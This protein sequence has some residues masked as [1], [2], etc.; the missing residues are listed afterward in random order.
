ME[1]FAAA[2]GLPT[3]AP[4]IICSQFSSN[5]P[6]ISYKGPVPQAWTDYCLVMGGHWVY[7]PEPRTILPHPNI[8]TLEE[9]LELHSSPPLCENITSITPE[10]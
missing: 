3:S 8:W 6:T 9:I 4:Q 10:E 5:T 1:Y 2:A 7:N